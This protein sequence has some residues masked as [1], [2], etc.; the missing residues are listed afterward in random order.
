MPSYVELVQAVIG[1]E[2]GNGMARRETAV[3][4]L[5]AI[6]EPNGAV[7]HAIDQNMTDD[8]ADDPNAWRGIIDVLI[9]G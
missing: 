1:K 5:R 7:L 6:R 8:P 4:V 9:S 3:N 2:L